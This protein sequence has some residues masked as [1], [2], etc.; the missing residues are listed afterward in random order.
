MTHHEAAP[1]ASSPTGTAVSGGRAP[2]IALL[3]RTIDLHYLAPAFEA[4]CPGVD[5]R[6]GDDLGALAD[7]DAAVCWYPPEGLLA[8]LPR[9][10]LVQSVGA[11][12]DHIL[13]D[14]ER[15][16]GV[17]VC[18]IL[19]DDMVAG[20]VAYVAWAV[21]RQQRHM[22]AYEASAA[23]GRWEEQPIVSP[24]RHRVGIAGLGRLGVACAAALAGIGYVLRGWSRR[25]K[26][27]LPA[28]MEAFHGAGGLAP[29]LAG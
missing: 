21:T 11:G 8:Q 19:D 15:P 22:A 17:P 2:C 14:R 10:R 24:R 25:P 9:L 4:E 12:V 5:L 16:A 28:G 1:G 29:F 27:G 7:I 3:S 13:A 18:R 20:M 6:L 26:S 23:A